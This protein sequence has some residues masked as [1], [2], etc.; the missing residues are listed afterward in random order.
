M[1]GQSDGPASSSSIASG[2]STSSSSATDALFRPNGGTP[3]NQSAPSSGQ[4]MLR[5]HNTATQQDHD[6]LKRRPRN[7]G[8][9][10]L[11]STSSVR[12]R[13]F[14]DKTELYGSGKDAK[15]K[16]K[17][18]DG[19][20]IVPKRR[21]LLHRHLLKPSLGSSPL[22]KEVVNV[23]SASGSE[24]AGKSD[25]HE[26]QS[27]P[28]RAIPS[29]QSSNDSTLVPNGRISKDTARSREIAPPQ[30]FDA[31]ATKLVNLAL[32]LS[33]SRRRNFSGGLLAPVNK[34][35]DRRVFSTGAPIPGT[36]TPVRGS[37]LQPHSQQQRHA[38]R[39]NTPREVR[40][41][42]H[43]VSS[44]KPTQ[45]ANVPIQAPL[46]PSLDP[47]GT[48]DLPFSP[49][50][51]TLSRAEKARVALELGYE[52]RRLLQYLPRL[53]ARSRGKPTTGRFG[54]KEIDEAFNELGRPYNP[55][56]YIRNRKV[57]LRE[58]RPLNPEADGWGD[59]D[60]VRNWVNTVAA[61]REA[62]IA[63]IDDRYPLPPLE[64]IPTQ[65]PAADTSP[66]VDG[67]NPSTL[68]TT[69]S[70]RPR[71]EWTFA[72]SDLLADAYWLQ[73]DGNITHI[74]DRTGHRILSSPQ[75]FKVPSARN[76]AELDRASHRR[77]VSIN[78]R[79]VSP[80]KFRFLVDRAK[81]ETSRER[82]YQQAETSEPDTP[83]RQSGGPREK[84]GRWHRR[85][86]RSRSSSSISGSD[87][88]I[89]SGH[90]RQHRQDQNYLDSAALEKH[91]RDLLEQEL[92][93]SHMSINHQAR[94]GA[95]G[96]TKG[97]SHLDTRTKDASDGVSQDQRFSPKEISNRVRS[98][99][100]R[101]FRPSAR[102]SFE[103]QR[104]RRPRKS[105]EEH[106]DATAHDSPNVHS[107]LPSIAVD[108]SRP[109]S[110]PSS[111]RELTPSRK[112]FR[113]GRS[114]ERQAISETDFAS[115]NKP[116]PRQAK[117]NTRD[118][119]SAE[120]AHP[121]RTDNA[122]NGFLSPTTAEGF[123]RRFRRSDGIAT[124]GNKEGSEA[125]SKIRGFFKGGRLAEIVGNEVSRVGDKLRRRDASTQASPVVSPA[126]SVWG[127]SDTEGDGLDSGMDADI[128]RVTT[129]TDGL[130]HGKAA[131]PKY[132]MD[133]LP[134][135]R[136]PLVKDK[137][138]GDI[139]EE[140]FD[141]M[142]KPL[143]SQHSQ[144]RGRSSRFRRLA[145]PKL[146]MRSISPSSLPP[147]T[148]TQTRNTVTS[149]DPF[150]SRQS[151]TSRSEA[152]V[153]DADRRLNAVLGTPG[154]IGRGGPPITGLATLE[155]CQRRARERPAVKDNR[156]WS[157]ADRGV[158]ATRGIVTKRD[159]A[160]VK[161]LL[162][163][164]GVK[165]NEIV[166]RAH[167]VSEKPSPLFQDLQSMS[168]GSLPRVCRTEEHNLA[169]RIYASNIDD[170]IQQLR[171]IAES[172]SNSALDDLHGQIK[173]V[174][175]QVT[176]KLTPSV[177]TC[178]DEA[179]AFSAQ[180]TSTHVIE[181]KQLN[182]SVDAVLRRRRRRLRWI[183]RG[184]FVVL[185]WTLLGIMWWVWLIVV[186][187]R[188][189]RGTIRGFFS[190]IRW[191]FWL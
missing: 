142:A 60:R 77:S 168:K 81:K 38:S 13:P 154:T 125:D 119:N 150:D 153:R 43:G 163:S 31:D 143:Q 73:H 167:E 52:Y 166:R 27:A 124:K 88:E 70:R 97:N 185:E 54:P 83:T 169:A 50:D 30:G 49:S 151:S 6:R 176:Q 84:K 118:P 59:I 11:S 106:F 111:P 117:S 121:E 126:S 74:E 144:E 16:E 155:I 79:A 95:G 8:G 184:G 28:S 109:N 53:P 72:A 115:I 181:I 71:L 162:L 116:L 23:A 68:Q 75:S 186:I 33:E 63:T 160:R 130:N 129:R 51:A 134:S 99:S 44:P 189:I 158:S 191:L 175:E 22:A 128:S 62:G 82:G 18:E 87:A 141:K 15:G 114:K 29:I 20:L 136:S 139:P 9:F 7:S 132:H 100:R 4:H 165:A 85:L 152:R 103:E 40:E 80:E 180:L 94:K 5:E 89:I 149:Y 120:V 178:A 1:S 105:L 64:V 55:L 147:L 140:T 26:T 133:N 19:E 14:Q 67:S 156:Q 159:I 12:S 45:E 183:R 177:R 61:E 104:G 78:R 122:S 108:L 170:T 135:F 56:Q 173:E 110:S 96:D 101:S 37:S 157:I 148:R 21:S 69:R 146:D 32:S 102:T 17:A 90:S 42:S 137:T 188:L 145:P 123:A 131:Q 112:G 190:A 171:G 174:D 10:L 36:A 161:A 47:N 65:S 187:I 179:D 138:T 93:E 66:S 25:G 35:G 92:E 76:S 48:V 107:F 164:S 39:D 58:R 127:E 46:G 24:Q 86:V 113:L 34:I 182:D 57:R 91:M 172:F 98:R 3:E 41:G 2:P